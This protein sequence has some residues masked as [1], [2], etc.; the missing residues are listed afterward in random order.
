M[1]FQEFAKAMEKL[2][3]AYFSDTT[4]VDAIR[5]AN[6]ALMSDLKFQ[7]SILKAAA[8]QGNANSKASDSNGPKNT[9]VYR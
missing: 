4:T 7:D 9:F 1:E 8:L 3:T 2:R 5:L 6:I